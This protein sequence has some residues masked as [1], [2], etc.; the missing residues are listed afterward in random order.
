MPYLSLGHHYW[1]WVPLFLEEV[2]QFTILS[3]L[4]P[5]LNLSKFWKLHPWRLFAR[6]SKNIS[7]NKVILECSHSLNIIFTPLLKHFKVNQMLSILHSKFLSTVVFYLTVSP[8]CTRLIIHTSVY[9]WIE[10]YGLLVLQK[11][12]FHIG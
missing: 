12:Y 4:I 7:S 3:Y 11:W 6:V 1:A 5:F 10:T 8:Y 2:T 9:T